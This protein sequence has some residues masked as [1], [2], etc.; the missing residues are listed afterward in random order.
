MFDWQNF[1]VSSIMFD[2][3]WQSNDWCSIGFDY[4][5]VR[6]D[7]PGYV[8]LCSEGG[9]IRETKTRTS[10]ID[11]LN[12]VTIYSIQNSYWLGWCFEL[13]TLRVQL[14]VANCREHRRPK[15]T[16]R[17]VPFSSIFTRMLSARN[18][19]R[20][21]PTSTTTQRPS[22]VTRVIYS[23]LVEENQKAKT[24]LKGFGSSWEARWQ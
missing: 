17:G 4:R 22:L 2:W 8:V 16:M 19:T 13:F 3:V 11:V 24:C 23:F 20:P 14:V 21:P 7:R 9:E 6:S 18:A 15:L 12:A 5:T 10:Y 1:I